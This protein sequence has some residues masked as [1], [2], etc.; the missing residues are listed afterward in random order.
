[1]RINVTL[2]ITWDGPDDMAVVERCIADA[3]DEETGFAS[4]IDVKAEPA[5]K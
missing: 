4:V 3:V 1:M 5:V 2:D